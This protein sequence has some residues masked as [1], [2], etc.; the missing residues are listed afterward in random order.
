M[1]SVAPAVW[2]LDRNGGKGN[3]FFIS[4][5]G[6]F[7]TNL[8]VLE[9]ILAQ[10]GEFEKL[11]IRKGIK[12]HQ[13]I[14]FLPNTFLRNPY[15]NETLLVS[16]A[17]VEFVSPQ[18]KHHNGWA[19]DYIFLKF[20][21]R[22]SSWLKISSNQPE[23]GDTIFLASVEPELEK[24]KVFPGV[25]SQNGIERFLTDAWAIPGMSGAPTLN[26]QGEV[27]G[28]FVGQLSSLMTRNDVAK[29]KHC[30]L[31]QPPASPC[32]RALTLR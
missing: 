2:Q 5:A 9:G 14:R 19:Q 21:F 32:A 25:V 10:S 8:H 31:P 22:P 6:D 4:E 17:S 24:F 11:N 27:V 23:V 1:E 28:I 18:R 7:V 29:S 20:N 15:T 12:T 13:L 3:G 26:S 30:Y 16:N